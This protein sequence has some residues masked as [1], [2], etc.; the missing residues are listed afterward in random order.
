MNT[1]YI[2]ATYL[3]KVYDELAREHYAL[4]IKMKDNKE[5]K[6][7]KNEALYFKQI[8]LFTRIMNDIVKLRNAREELEK[9]EIA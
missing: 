1:D 4:M 3:N 6:F 5:E 9:K 2:T 7:K 8:N